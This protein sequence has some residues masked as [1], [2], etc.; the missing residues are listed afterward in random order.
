[1]QEHVSWAG[2]GPTCKESKPSCTPWGQGRPQQY[3]ASRKNRRLDHSTGFT[4]RKAQQ[5]NLGGTQ[6]STMKGGTSLR[7]LPKQESEIR[8]CPYSTTMGR[9]QQAEAELSRPLH[10]PATGQS[11]L[12]PCIS[13]L[14]SSLEWTA[15]K[16]FE[17]KVFD[18][19]KQL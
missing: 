13:I 2:V 11:R 9:Q 16:I 8:Q 7:D 3:E 10:L 18:N 19:V 17:L 1:M 12:R 5:R 6:E 4:G 15:I 14:S